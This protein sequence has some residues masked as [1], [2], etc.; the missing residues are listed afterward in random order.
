MAKKEQQSGTP[1]RP[2][3]NVRAALTRHARIWLGTLST[4][5]AVATG[6]FALRDEVFPGEAGTAAAVSLPVY[7]QQVGRVCDQVN[8]DDRDR[9]REDTAL[10]TTLRFALTPIAQRNLLLDPVRNTTARSER[11]FVF[12]YRAGHTDDTRRRAPRH[13]SGLEPQPRAVARLRRAP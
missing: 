11:T 6:M 5:I 4:L 10:R 1:T 7:Q 9:A 12:L 3:A 2:P 13:R 8:D